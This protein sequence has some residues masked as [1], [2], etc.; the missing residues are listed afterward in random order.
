MTELYQIIVL[1][2]GVVLLALLAAVSAFVGLAHACR[3]VGKQLKTLTLVV[4]SF[5]AIVATVL[6][7][8]SGRSTGTT[9]SPP[10][11]AQQTGTTGVPPVGNEITNTLHFAAIDMHTTGTSTLLIAW[12]PSLLAADATLDLFAATS[13]VDSIWVWQCEH[14]VAAGE[15]NWLVAVSMPQA[16]PG[17]NAPSA[18]FYVS[19]RETCADTMADSD[20]DGLPDVYEL[21]NGTNPYVPDYASA[22][23]L[24]VGQSGDFTDIQSALMA[25]T[26]YS[27]IELDQSAQHEITDSLGVQLPQ[28]PVMVTTS[29][30]YAVVR[31]TGTTAFML[32]TNTTTRTLFKNLYLLLDAKTSFQVGFWCGGNLPWDGVPAAATFDNVYVRM[33]NPNVQY[34]GW[35]FYRHCADMAT[36]RSCTVNAAGATWAVGI[37]A[38]GSPPLA[39]NGCSFVNFPPD[40]ASNAGCGALLRTSGASD[41][42]SEVT[43]SRSIFDESFTNAWP[44]A[45]FD[46]ANP[47]F[48]TVSDCLTPRDLPTEYL[49]D[50]SNSITV[51]NA[52]LAWSGIP[53][54]GSPS[55]ALGI[56]SLMPIADD[57][58]VDTDGDGLCDYDEA[59]ERGTDPFNADSDND[60]VDDRTEMTIDETGPTNPHSFKQR[61]TVSVTNTVSLTHAIYT[62]WGYAES[63]WETNGLATFPQGC[64]T[65][66]YLDASSQGATHIKAFCDMNDDGEYD[67]AYDILL[68]RDIPP[69]AMAQV[70]FVFGDVD[71]DGVSDARERQEQTDPYDAKNFRFIVTVN[72]ESSDVVPGLTN[73]VAWGYLPTGWETNDHGTFAGNSLVF[74]VDGVAVNGELYIKVF[75]DF[76]TN[77]V[78]DAGVDALVARKLTGT[79][80]GK[81]V[82]FSI[83]DSDNDRIADS[84]ELKEGT[85]PL[86]N[87]EYCFNLSQTYT[88]VFQ[89]TNALTF[90]AY[91]GT[92]RVHG[93]CVVADRIWTYDFGHRV[94]T[95]GE[96]ASVSVWDDANH[97][98]E[99]DVGETSNR[100]VI[101]ITGHDMVVTN[102]LT[103]GNF[104]HDGNTLPDWWE[105]QEGLGAEG[106][107]RRVYDDPDGDGLINLHEYWCGTHPL[108]PDGSNTLLSVASRSIDDRIRDIDPVTAIPRFVNYF[109]NGSNDVFQ[110]NT[111]FWAR[112]LDLSC[113]NVWHDGEH[114]GTKA[115]TLITRK[116]VVM[117]AH[118]PEYTYRFCD[119]N[120]IVMTRTVVQWNNLSDDLRLGRLNEPLPESFKPACVPSTNIVRY[121]ATGKYLPTLSINQEKGATILELEALD[122]EAT[123]TGGGHYFHYGHINYTNLVTRPRCSVRG[124]TVDGNSG[125]PVFLVVGNE[126]VLLF[127]NHLGWK[128]VETWSRHWGPLLPFRLD[129]VQRKIDEWEGVDADLYQIVPFDVNSYDEIVNP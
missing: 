83:G 24:T 125:C 63:G 68:V 78:Y 56:G 45:R 1:R 81:A 88:G 19:N 43:I 72:I 59:Y 29:N 114:K 31:A 65:N 62:A 101:A 42:G 2:A 10:G 96:K 55:V 34:R 121:L 54:P 13:L 47:Y 70:N 46:T 120:G 21:A 48:V 107:A 39:I 117:A 61:L 67:S 33:P 71:G 27:I 58:L 66:L 105:A 102:A 76:N 40:G 60:G 112:D 91:F 18:F 4:I 122:S 53:Y 109:V 36:I 30:S 80:N 28:H 32:A 97:N 123:R 115:A 9:G 15:T 99:W 128:N 69:G 38:Y 95:S 52:A 44:L 5:L 74:S 111:N 12:P 110:L 37:D 35:M 22:P 57:P 7:Q 113:V 3:C 86:S 126:L 106:I 85:N 124:A 116:H 49:P 93:P 108:V 8:K 16:S 92:N 51:T 104:D 73:F 79:D 90:A 77:G 129:A 127:S 14:Q 20:R 26:D 100:Y 17:A 119:T 82:T 87:L 89:T 11:T 84:V 98:G 23:K 41:S 103:Y 118:W 6:A 25:S 94:A 75:R 50:I 64:G